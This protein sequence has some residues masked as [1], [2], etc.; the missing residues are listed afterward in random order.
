MFDYSYFKIKIICW[1]N[2]IGYLIIGCT[3]GKN[4][5]SLITDFGEGM[6]G[7]IALIAFG[8]TGWVQGIFI[9]C[10]AEIIDNLVGNNK[11]LCDIEEKIRKS[12]EITNS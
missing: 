3:L 5:I 7:F 11:K 8:I 12:N 6:S 2:F 9:N 10:I 4:Y 1:L